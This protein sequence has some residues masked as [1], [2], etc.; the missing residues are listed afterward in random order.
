MCP[1]VYFFASFVGFVCWPEKIG[2]TRKPLTYRSLISF[3][4]NNQL[5]PLVSAISAV[6]VKN[7]AGRT[8]VTIPKK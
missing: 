7:I 8:L 6:K 1:F 4:T 3:L 5:V 2:Y